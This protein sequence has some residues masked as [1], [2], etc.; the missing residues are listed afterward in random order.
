MSDH[1]LISYNEGHKKRRTGKIRWAF[2]RMHGA[3]DG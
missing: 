1:G 2:S 3:L